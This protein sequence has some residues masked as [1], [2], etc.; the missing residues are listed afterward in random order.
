MSEF[1]HKNL[2][3]IIVG[4]SSGI[5]LATA[6]KLASHGLNL[7]LIHK[8]RRSNLKELNT[9]FNTLKS[10]GVQVQTYNIDAVSTESITQLVHQISNTLKKDSAKI[11]VFL[12]SIAQ[13][14]LKP[15]L[16]D[17]KVGNENEKSINKAEIQAFFEKMNEG[18]GDKILSK[19][20]FMLTINSMGVSFFEWVQQLLLAHIFCENAR[21]IGLTSEGSV[22]VWKGY[23]AVASSKSIIETLIKYFAVELAPLKITANLIQAGVTDTPSLRLIPGSEF[24]KEYTKARNPN[25]RLTQPTDIANVIYLLCRDEADWITGTT[26]VADGGESLI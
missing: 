9:H 4:G 17:K 19:S 5:G 18:L 6:Y 11:K 24:L 22:K 3:A 20:D 15:L 10:I 26:I 21:I 8:D 25:N 12:H 7:I 14:N 1:K 16:P 13:G 23:S 2:W